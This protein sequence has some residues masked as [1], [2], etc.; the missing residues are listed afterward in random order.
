MVEPV[1]A[2]EEP[3]AA[4]RERERVATILANAE[5]DPAGPRFVPTDDGRLTRERGVSPS[6][7]R[8]ADDP[9]LR[10]MQLIIA[11]YAAELERAS[12]RLRNREVWRG[13]S[14]TAGNLRAIVALEPAEVVRELGL[15]YANLLRLGRYLESDGR[16]RADPS[17]NDDPLD[18]EIHGALTDL[19]RTAAPWL[20]G[21]PTVARWDD[22]AGK[23]LARPRLESARGIAEAA[24]RSGAVAG[25]DAA[26]AAILT[27]TAQGSGYLAEKAGRRL[28]GWA[29]NLIVVGALF[30]ADVAKDA[31]VRGIADHSP[32]A[33]RV[34]ET[35]VAAEHHIEQ[36]AEDFPADLRYAVGVALKQMRGLAPGNGALIP[37]ARETPDPEDIQVRARAMVLQGEA[38]PVEWRPFI[39]SLDFPFE[40]L[41]DVS[42]LSG[43]V[44]MVSLDLRGTKVTDVSPLSGLVALERL[45]LTGTQVA[46]VSPLSGL[47]ALQSLYL[48]GTQVA[49]V[50]P[51][52]GLVALRALDL[53]GTQ[54]ADASPLSGL[55]ALEWLDLRRTQVADV[56]PLSGLVA[57]QSLH[58]S[59]TQVA[60]V[61]PLSR[62]V[63]LRRLDVKDTNVVD[64]S[65]LRHL[66]DLSVVAP[67]AAS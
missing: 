40:D 41:S 42:P 37:P 7:L 3:A 50:S 23:L 55:V 54:V 18:A 6:D 60:D 61:S 17:A 46:D 32:L 59:E 44:A 22:E 51:L 56:S 30:C 21:F 14:G 20:R 12:A 1:S 2:G 33:E 36:I 43:L 53:E 62:L 35:F 29:R 63:A 27:E 65:S 67:N 4:R 45:D 28:V 13:L 24:Q 47:V 31:I 34:A 39:R 19:V 66:K 38:P 49:D 15:A 8:A 48:L 9:L 10:Q 52:S 26:E 5:L 11:N 57:L 16:L 58:L 64:I 25:S